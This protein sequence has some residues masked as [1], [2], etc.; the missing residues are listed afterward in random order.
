MS[1][2]SVG[3]SFFKVQVFSCAKEFTMKKLLMSI[4]LCSL[5]FANLH[6]VDGGGRY[7][8]GKNAK[9]AAVEHH[10]NTAKN[11]E[12]VLA[13][14]KAAEKEFK[15]IDPALK[16]AQGKLKEAKESIAGVA[17]PATKKALM[18]ISDYN[19]AL[20]NAVVQMD[21]Y[22]DKQ[23]ESQ[24]KHHSKMVKQHK[25]AAANKKGKKVVRKNVKF[26]QR[27]SKVASKK[28]DNKTDTSKKM[29]SEKPV[30]EVASEEVTHTVASEVEATPAA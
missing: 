21:E 9:L 27:V 3:S 13:A 8:A 29:V 26:G 25:N 17:D 18:E 11:H 30:K 28:I 6:A 12:E 4:A 22:L 10:E 23:H 1:V 2:S 20:H 24:V 7:T 19:E 14:F 5:A 16:N 15:E